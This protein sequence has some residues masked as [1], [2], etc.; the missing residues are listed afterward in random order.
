MFKISIK[1]FNYHK[2]SLFL[3]ALL[4]EAKMKFK[5]QK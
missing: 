5:M 2:K 3:P 1:I 4:P